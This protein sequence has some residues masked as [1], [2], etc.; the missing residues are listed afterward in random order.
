MLRDF[1]AQFPLPTA[2]IYAKKKAPEGAFSNPQRGKIRNGDERP[3]GT[4]QTSC[5]LQG[6]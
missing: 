3:V 4:S 1:H 6:R 2:H 5:Q